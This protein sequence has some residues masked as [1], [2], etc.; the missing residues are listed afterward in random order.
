MS[1]Y[2]SA[3]YGTPKYGTSTPAN[4][5]WGLVVDWDEDGAY[6]SDNE[7]F[8]L[9]ALEIE[10]GRTDYLEQA[11]G[12]VP[13]AI[14]RARL[15]L[16]NRDGRYNPYNTSGALY[17][18][19][20]TGK[21]AQIVV[22]SG[23]TTYTVF[24]GVIQE[25]NPVGYN[26]TV[27][28]VIEDGLRWLADQ[29]VETT[30]YQQTDAKTAIGA[31]LDAAYWPTLWGRDLGS[32]ADLYDYWWARGDSA[33]SEIRTLTDSEIGRFHVAADGEFMFRSRQTSETSALSVTQSELLANPI[34]PQPWSFRRNTVKV[35]AHP[36]AEQTLA[37]VWRSTA[38]TAVSAGASVTVTA[39]L[40]TAAV[41]LVTPVMTT[42][43]LANRQSDGHGTDLSANIST[44]LSVQATTATITLTN[45][46]TQLAYVTFLQV[47]GYALEESSVSATATGSGYDR[48]PRTLEL[49]LTWQQDA[50]NPEAFAGQMVNFLNTASPFPTVQVEQRPTV[51]FAVD[52]FD[53]VD[54]SLAAIGISDT[55]RLGYIY[56]EWLTENGQAVRTTWKF[57]PRMTYN[58]WLFDSDAVL[59][60]SLLGW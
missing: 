4:L 40:T 28:I 39:E 20:G 13:L 55:Y 5:R 49:N 33:L 19:V 37:Q 35:L 10:R 15:T 56:H 32:G 16:R 36:K 26:Q 45:T 14:G 23:A 24:T 18:N 43:F 17:P 27:E 31:I 38:V 25:I 52:L 30:I 41:N 34:I 2:K 9:T 11:G 54:V 22:R 57:E 8:N 7:A 12:F 50:N 42:D 29:N 59:D 60:T 1:L 47:R 48:R 44:S 51:Q 21:L 53:L 46:G 6:D 58:F 3:K